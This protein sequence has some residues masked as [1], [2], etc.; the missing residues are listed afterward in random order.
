MIG[1]R[2]FELDDAGSALTVSATIA[3]ALGVALVAILKGRIVL[4]AVGLFVVPVG[5]VGALRLA[6]PSSPWARRRYQPGSER[7]RRARRALR[8]RVAARAPALERDRRRAQPQR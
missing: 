7:M 3:V 2:P 8:T 1:V 4:G 5:L 6:R